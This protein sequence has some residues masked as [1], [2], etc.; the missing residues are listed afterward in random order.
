MDR[1]TDGQIHRQTE[2]LTERKMDS[3]WSVKQTDEQTVNDRQKEDDQAH[4]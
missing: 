1:Q 3:S 4:S 2:G